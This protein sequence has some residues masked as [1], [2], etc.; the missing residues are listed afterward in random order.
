MTDGV[1][2]GDTAGSAQH[3]SNALA[4]MGLLRHAFEP[5]EVAILLSNGEE[6]AADDPE[7]MARKEAARE[8]RREHDTADVR[9]A[10]SQTSRQHLRD[11]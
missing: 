1:G 9:D 2:S 11:D 3:P 6:G 7:T 8:L 4:G 5:G 10:N